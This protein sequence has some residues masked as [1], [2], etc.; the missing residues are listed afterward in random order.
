MKNTRSM[1]SCLAHSTHFTDR[2]DRDASRYHQGVYKRKRADLVGVID[3]TLSPLFLGQLKNLHKACLVKYKQEMVDG[4][5]GEGYNFAEVVAAARE[6]LEKRF[7]DGAK[8]AL[9]E[10][11]DWSYEEELQLL[12]DEARSV[13]DQ[14]RKDET[15]KMVNVIEVRHSLCFC[16]NCRSCY[17]NP[18]SA[19]SR[20]KYPNLLISTS[21]SLP[22]T[23]GIRYSRCSGKPSKKP[24][25]RIWAR[26]RVRGGPLVA[27]VQ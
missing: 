13:A 21:T 1:R 6:R 20:S 5:R 18:C 7:L 19:T 8:E 9:V 24:R 3:S 25:H 23:C 12:R 2:Y 11:T 4:M 14:C 10:G 16:V 26:P 27:D 17:T 15:K 22:Q